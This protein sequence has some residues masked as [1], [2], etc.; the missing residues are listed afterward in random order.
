MIKALNRLRG[1]AGSSAPLFF[2]IKK[3]QG[4]LCLCP[5]DVEAQASWPPPGYAPANNIDNGY[6]VNASSSYS[7][8]VSFETLQEF[9]SRPENVHDVWLSS[10]LGMSVTTQGGSGRQFVTGP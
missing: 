4:F 2:T 1:C 3:S 10:R 9:L 8:V 5:Y 6:V 7:L